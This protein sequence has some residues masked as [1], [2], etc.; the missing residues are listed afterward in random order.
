MSLGSGWDSGKRL[1]RSDGFQL[2]IWLMQGK[3]HQIEMAVVNGTLCE[4]CRRGR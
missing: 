1:L 4:V 3:M 2:E